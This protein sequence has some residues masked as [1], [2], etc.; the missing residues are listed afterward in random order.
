MNKNKLK[1]FFQK[2]FFRHPKTL[3][4]LY[5]LIGLVAWFMKYFRNAYNNYQIFKGVFW[6]TWLQKPL[7][8]AYPAEYLDTNHYGPFFS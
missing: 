4:G 2:P 1:H 5:V 6:H 8:E 7:Y 3:L